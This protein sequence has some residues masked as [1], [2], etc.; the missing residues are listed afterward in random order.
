M[1]LTTVFSVLIPMTVL[2]ADGN[3]IQCI[4][5][6]NDSSY[7]FFASFRINADPKCLLRIS[8]N[9]EHIRAVASDAKDILLLDSGSNW[10]RISYTYQKYIFFE[11]TSVWLRKLDRE[12]QRVDFTLVSSKN[13][14]VLIPMLISSSGYFQI[15]Q[16][17]DFAIVEYY[18]ECRITEKAITKLYASRMKN[19][20]VKFINLFAVYASENCNGSSITN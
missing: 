4:F 16:D 19:E 10:N 13:N 9:Y 1:F 8:F 17:K 18:Q 12:K 20:A 7:S 5:N 2:T 14:L 6:Q 3:D 15:K 11:N